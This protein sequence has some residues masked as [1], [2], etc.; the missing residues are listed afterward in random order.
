MSQASYGDLDREWMQKMADKGRAFSVTQPKA[1]PPP[2]MIDDR[3]NRLEGFACEDCG[4]PFNDGV[5]HPRRCKGCGGED[6]SRH[7]ELA[8]YGTHGMGGYGHERRSHPS[9]IAEPDDPTVEEIAWAAHSV[10]P[11]L[12]H[13][14]ALALA[15]ATKRAA[16]I[17]AGQKIAQREGLREATL[18]ALAQIEA[19]GRPSAGVS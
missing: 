10:T 16:L 15:R 14:A 11:P 2:P 3:D 9:R 4:E 7:A 8:V 1:T 17:A 19:I 18:M 6:A 5:G 13:R 12:R